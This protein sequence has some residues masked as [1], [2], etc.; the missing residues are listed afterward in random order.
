[1]VVVG[2]C[3]KIRGDAL[4]VSALTVEITPPVVN[5]IILAVANKMDAF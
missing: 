4:R 2:V 1:M 3:A 5:K